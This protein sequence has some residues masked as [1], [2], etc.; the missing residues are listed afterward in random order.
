[1]EILDEQ[2]T[3]FSKQL[4]AAIITERSTIAQDMF[5]STFSSTDVLLFVML[6]KDDKETIKTVCEDN[7]SL[8]EEKYN[9]VKYMLGTNI[10]EYK[11]TGEE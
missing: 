7:I 2:I 5:G 8:L 1:M 11:F 4:N 3:P 10:P 9:F 6:S